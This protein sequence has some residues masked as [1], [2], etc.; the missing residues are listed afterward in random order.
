M[1]KQQ[2][3]R[4]KGVV[5]GGQKRDGDNLNEMLENGSEGSV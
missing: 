5:G 1:T 4:S 2:E 3:H